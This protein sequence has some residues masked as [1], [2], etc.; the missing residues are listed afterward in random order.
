MSQQVTVTRQLQLGQQSVA[1]RAKMTDIR[2]Y[3]VNISPGN[4]ANTA[5]S[6]V[7]YA[8]TGVALGDFLVPSAPYDLTDVG[9]TAY[10]QAADAIELRFINHGATANVLLAAGDWKMLVIKST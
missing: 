9:V 7:T 6:T 4:I 10:V 8:A 2:V 1:N 5:G 3:T